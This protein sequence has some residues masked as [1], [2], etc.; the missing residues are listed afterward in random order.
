[1]LAN[2]TMRSGGPKGSGNATVAVY[3][4]LATVAGGRL[5]ADPSLA[6]ASWQMLLSEMPQSAHSAGSAR[7]RGRVDALALRSRFTDV[8]CYESFRPVAG[9]G[10][11]LFSLLEQ[12]RVETLGARLFAGMW[13]NLA[14]LAE[15]RWVRARPEV[16][17]RGERADW[18]ETFALVTRMPLGSPLPGPAREGLINSWRSWMSAAEAREVLLLCAAI[19]EPELFARQA[20]RVVEA[21]LG[22]AQAVPRIELSPDSAREQASQKS[23]SSPTRAESAIDAPNA[24]HRAA[25]RVTD[26]DSDAAG[27]TALRLDAASSYRVY[28]TAFD[29]VVWASDLYDAASLARRRAEL[30]RSLG[31][32]LSGV[33]RWAHRLHRKLMSMQMRSWQFDREEGV[34][35]GARIT[36]IITR[37]L[38]PLLYK[39]ESETEFADTVVTLLVDNSGSM[40]GVPI[41]T[42]AVCAELLGRVLERCSVK[43]EILGFTTRSWRGGR[44]YQQWVLAG[45]PSGPGRLTELRHVIYKGADE[46]WRRARARMGAILADDL[47][48]ENVD[49]EALWWAHERLMRRPEQRKILLVISDGAPLDDATL[50]ANDAGYLAR[51]LQAVIAAIERKAS[52]ELAGIGIG[53]AVTGYYRRAVTLRSVEDL[54]EA[55]VTQLIELFGAQRRGP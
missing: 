39:Q 26:A 10:L 55:I 25:P 44:P 8:K 11:L 48:K 12:N 37:P 19:T 45:R 20:L 43:T 29:S 54:G 16:V 6:A 22:G 40:R 18:I 36:R 42:A 47:L 21:V 14:A 31:G 3:R 2:P 13:G 23:E 51:H 46:P 1:M 24:K 49:G 52:V 50:E 9:P 15:E 53:H 28:T 4:A 32:H 17:I 41:A 5:A 27:E 33:A 35:D 38:E 30:D 7:W 34:L